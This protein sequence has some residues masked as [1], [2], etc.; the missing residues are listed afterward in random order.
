MPGAINPSPSLSTIPEGGIGTQIVGKEEGVIL[1]VGKVDAESDGDDDRV[2]EIDGVNATELV[3][4]ADD[5][6]DCDGCK[7]S[8]G[9]L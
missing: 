3:T 7:N 9:M 8:S 5:I 6:L 1:R 2:G 4:D